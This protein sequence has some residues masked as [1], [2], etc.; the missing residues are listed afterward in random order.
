MKKATFLVLLLA[1]QCGAASKVRLYNLQTG[2]MSTLV[3]KNRFWSGHGSVSRHMADGRLVSGEFKTIAT[4]TQEQH[5]NAILT[6]A[7]G[8][9][10]DCEYTVSTLDSHGSG[11]CTDS[12]GIR[13]RLIF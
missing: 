4:R 8:F 7:G 10:I 11:V 9:I 12:E 1:L 13:Y 2:A 3:Y 5:G 6:G